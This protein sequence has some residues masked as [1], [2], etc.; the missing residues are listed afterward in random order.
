[1]LPRIIQD[2][3]TR[4]RVNGENGA[5]K[6]ETPDLV[7]TTH[8]IV[9]MILL[10]CREERPALYMV[11][12]DRITEY[13]WDKA[14]WG[15]PQGLPIEKSLETVEKSRNEFSVFIFWDIVQRLDD[16]DGNPS[17]RCF[18][19]QF[20]LSPK[21]T[22]KFL[23]FLEPLGTQYPNIITPYITSATE[24]YPSKE[25]LIPMIKREVLQGKAEIKDKEAEIASA[26]LGLTYSGGQ[27]ML[28]LALDKCRDNVDLQKGLL[29]YLNRQ[30]EEILAHTLGMNIL[31][32]TSSDVP[33]GL[34]FLMK[35]LEI[36]RHL[37]CVEGQDREK[38]WLLI[39]TPGS[40]K[41]LLAKYLGY[42]MGY[43][44]ISFN[45]SS[46]MNSLVGQT[47]KNMYNLCKIL[48][49]FAPC[50]FYIDEF[51]KAIS[52]GHEMD[53]G[54]MTRA[55]GILFTWL[56]DTNAPI[57]LLASANNLDPQHGL[58]LTRK[59]R[60][61]Q[62]YWVGEPCYEARHRI[63]KAN[64]QRKGINA[65]G[66]LIKELAEKTCYF[67]GADLVWLINEVIVESKHYK[68]SPDSEQFKN[69]V[70]EL[71]EENKGRVETMKAQYDPLRNWAKAYCKPAGLPPEK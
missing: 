14:E 28:R 47:E 6:I 3:L 22:R 44:A 63:S 70:M 30:K 57:F 18:I 29:D 24:H 27:Q 8:E 32:P 40:G 38:G 33:Y 26:L 55:M 58:A 13:I 61:S 71:I 66:S 31:K 2:V 23:V 65:S 56:N 45:I 34:D 67:S 37:I 62:I 10:C 48:E 49:T 69:R 53:G 51:E 1:M 17:V 50:V 68:Y 12:L 43:P 54:T 20:F 5:I 41:S 42:Q 9:D 46:I 52:S 16:R 19:P 15:Q 11:R 4:I 59:G 39:G 25:E 36:H 64:F 60:F 21:A 35:D 7:H